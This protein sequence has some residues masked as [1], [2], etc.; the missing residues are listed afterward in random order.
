MASSRPVSLATSALDHY[1]NIPLATSKGDFKKPTSILYYSARTKDYSGEPVDGEEA[2][3]LGLVS[4]CVD[5]DALQDKAREI[6][7]RLA[8]G[9]PAAIR[10]TKYALNTWYR[11]MGPAFDASTAFEMLGFVGA[12]G[13]EG[14]DALKENVVGLGLEA[15]T[16]IAQTDALNESAWRSSGRARS[17]WPRSP[18]PRSPTRGWPRCTR[19][20]TP[21]RRPR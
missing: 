10:W 16:E 20:P 12:E 18:R 5:D 13:R 7:S 21:R 6:A 2:D 11:M 4:L 8:A 3:R 14:L 9:A 17:D 1:V 19:S 15:Q